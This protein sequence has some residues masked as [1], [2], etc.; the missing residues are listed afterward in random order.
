LW[1]CAIP[2]APVCSVLYDCS[3]TGRNF[4]GNFVLKGV[5]LMLV[6]E[7]L[8]EECLIRWPSSSAFPINLVFSMEEQKVVC[9]VSKIQQKKPIH[10]CLFEHICLLSSKRNLLKTIFFSNEYGPFYPSGESGC[11]KMLM[12]SLAPNSRGCN[13]KW[14]YTVMLSL[15]Y[16][17]YTVHFST[18]QDCSWL[19]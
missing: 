4:H 3:L 14:N 12:Y 17:Y 13:K 5:F 15:S 2:S 18:T 7:L 19:L 9:W 8:D 10:F 11:K 6:K 16:K 1:P